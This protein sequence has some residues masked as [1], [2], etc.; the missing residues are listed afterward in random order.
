MTDFEGEQEMELEALAAIF[1][2]EFVPDEQ[3]SAPARGCPHA[4]SPLSGVLSG[5]RRTPRRSSA[6]S[7][8]TLSFS[9]PPSRWTSSARHGERLRR[10]PLPPHRAPLSAPSTVHKCYRAAKRHLLPGVWW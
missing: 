10:R 5:P 6:S 4:V 9:R 7:S 8:T 1:M 3:V 2:D